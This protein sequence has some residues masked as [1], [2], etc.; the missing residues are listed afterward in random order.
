[1]K[2][3]TILKRPRL[4]GILICAIV[5]LAYYIPYIVLGQ[6]SIIT[7]HDNL[8]AYLPNLVTQA[9]YSQW[10]STGEYP[11]MDG[12]FSYLSLQDW[13]SV[14]MLLFIFMNPF[15]A[16]LFNDM[17]VRA[18]AIIFMF[19]LLY[20]YVI[21][22]SRYSMI[23]SLLS[24]IA[25]AFVATYTIFGLT[26]SGVP[27]VMWCVLNIRNG[28]KKIESFILMALLPLFSTLALTGLYIGCV[29][30][31][32]LLISFIRKE[33]NVWTL[34]WASALMVCLY[35]LVN[36]PMLL[37]F[38]N[39]NGLTNRAEFHSE[40]T[41]YGIIDMAKNMFLYGQYH[42]GS[43]MSIC[44]IIAIIVALICN[45]GVDKPTLYMFIGIVAIVSFATLFYVI[46]NC[47]PG[48]RFVQSF[49]LDRFYIFLL[50]LWILL[51]ARSL[52]LICSRKYMKY[53][54]FAFAIITSCVF[55]YTNKEFKSNVKL[56]LGLSVEEVPYNHFYDVD[57]FSMIKKDMDCNNPYEHKVVSVGMYPGIALY[58][59]FY[60]LDA[61]LSSY[62]LQYKHK[63]KEVILPELEKDKNL[64]K[65][66][67]NWGSRC[68]LFSADCGKRYMYGKNDKKQITLDINVE[69]LRE[70]GCEYIFSAV[71]ISNYEQ[72]GID[73]VDTYSNDDSYWEIHV[74]K[75]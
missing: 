4:I 55:I 5:L 50:P 15:A 57:L 71:D 11:V 66:Y 68:Y 74:Y 12:N 33:K 60:T 7:I 67:D 42:Y 14:K 54:G 1:M 40:Y 38:V 41:W 48:F 72:L 37:S 29:L 53:F 17:L 56:M 75:I 36:V 51:L 43:Y 34:F 46:K 21:Q 49:Q 8:D 26:S 18:I 31:V 63:F 20:D 23:I 35:V 59:Q 65:Y 70:L 13:I 64:C 58:N 16:Y 24:S 52:S 6:D 30:G 19:L 3:Q 28:V 22:S 61:Y 2:M 45:R 69:K 47:F 32:Y 39:S 44:C 73:Y 10:L 25:F 9:N 27:L 62:P